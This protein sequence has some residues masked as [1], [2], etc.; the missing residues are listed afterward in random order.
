MENKIFLE[1]MRSKRSNDTSGGLSVELKGNKRLLPLNDVSNVISLMEQYT[2][3]REKCNI[4]R[5]TCQVNPICSNVLFNRIT[6]VVKYEGSDDVCL[7]N[8][9]TESSKD[10]YK[11]FKDKNQVIYKPNSID[12]WSGGDM[13]YQ[14]IDERLAAAGAESDLNHLN[15][16]DIDENGKLTSGYKHPTNAIRDTQLSKNDVNGD[17]FVYHCGLDI[18]NNHLIRSNTFKCICKMP[19]T[20]EWNSKTQDKDNKDYTWTWDTGNTEYTAF[21]TIADIMRDAK[22]DK[23]IEKLYFPTTSG[24]DGGVKFVGLHTY[25]YDDILTFNDAVRNRLIEKHNGWFGFSN[26][27]KIKSYR[28]FSSNGD[29]KDLKMERPI[30]YMNGG[31][32]VDMYPGRELYSFV[33]LYNKYRNR[34]EKNW[35]YCITYPSSSTTDGFDDIIE[36]SNGSLK[37]IYFDE[38]TRAD[39]GSMQLAMYSKAKHGLKSGDRV[40]IYKNY[41]ITTDDN[42]TEDVTELIIANVE[43]DE[44]VDEFIFTTFTQGVQISKNW[45]Q[46]KSEDFITGFTIGTS[47]YHIANDGGKYFY[48]DDFTRYF[49]V[50]DKYVNID[51]TAQ[52]ITYKKVVNDIEC[53]YY[54]RIF[55]R[56]PNFRF[57]SGDTNTEYS[58]YNRPLVGDKTGESLL[59]IYQKPEYGFESHVSRLAFARNIYSDEIGE[60]VFTDDINIANIHDNLGRPLTD[61]F[62][63]IVKNNAG[64]KEWYNGFPSED[65]V[66]FSHCFG[67]ITCGFEMSDES[68]GDTYANNIKLITNIKGINTGYAVDTINNRDDEEVFVRLDLTP[69]EINFKTDVHYYGDLC[70]YDNYNAVE[71]SIQ[72]IMHRFNTAQRESKLADKGNY[73]STFVYDEIHRDDYDTGDEFVIKTYTQSDCNNKPEGYYYNPHYRIRVKSFGKLN[74]AMP[75]FLSIQSIVK[76]KDIAEITTQQYHFLTP[77]DK[78]MIYDMSTEKY[79][80]LTTIPGKNDNSRVFTCKIS[81]ENG[82]P[83]MDI[84]GDNLSSYKLFKID[85]MAIPSYAHLLKDGTCRYIWRDVINN[86]SMGGDKTIEEYPFT[87]GAF[88]INRHIDL[89]VRRQDPYDQYGLYNED[90]IDVI[91]IDTPIEKINDYYSEDEIKC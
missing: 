18:L 10:E 60:V 2:E 80:Y 56:L 20:P 45:V 17:H 24:V 87:N 47:V 65:T 71:Q 31:D 16:T 36:P 63:T 57:S 38:N 41:T 21:N 26:K 25:L 81:T 23:V 33:P 9:G 12:F 91:G 78:A 77:G 3:E 83:T 54:V 48:D 74:T 39:S 40:N 44:V 72:Y 15:R 68:T 55:S 8:Y 22:G 13:S 27:S 79:Y 4:V 11:P 32:F 35:N 14:S 19:D 51:P 28:D 75:Q 43:V 53:D 52:N 82:N 58:I 86:G 66:E 37:T 73:F 7:L 89:F 50:N 62:V 30:M 64:Y 29:P 67:K 85:N 69:D 6:E 84:D 59:E 90:D 88:Y 61:I 5:L 49:I 70:C 76:D 42:K 1:R 34:M 46:L